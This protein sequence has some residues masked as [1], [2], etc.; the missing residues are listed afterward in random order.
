MKKLAVMLSMDN[1]SL[2]IVS[3]LPE[4]L[5]D[6]RMALAVPTIFLVSALDEASGLLGSG[7]YL[8]V[9][10]FL[11]GAGV[12]TGVG[13]SH[14]A[15][16]SSLLGRLALSLWCR[17][18]QDAGLP[19][20][21]FE[22]AQMLTPPILIGLSAGLHALAL[23]PS[24]TVLATLAAMLTWTCCA[25]LLQSCG[26]PAA[27]VKHSETA[28]GPSKL[29]DAH[30]KPLPA[31]TAG[32]ESWSG[33]WS[34]RP[35]SSNVCGNSGD[36]KDG[37]SGH[38]AKFASALR[39]CTPCAESSAGP[40]LSSPEALQVEPAPLPPAWQEPRRFRFPVIKLMLIATL[41]LADGGI[42]VWQALAPRCS[43]QAVTLA[44]AAPLFCALAALLLHV[45]AALAR[46]RTGRAHRPDA[47]S[48]L[49]Q[50][51][52]DA[53]ICDGE[54]ASSPASAAC[55]PRRSMSDW[56]QVA[57]EAP[58][59]SAVSSA[60]ALRLV[61]LWA[62][63]LAGGVAGGALGQGAAASLLLPVLLGFTGMPKVAASATVQL[64][65][66]GASAVAAT[67]L[68]VMERDGPALLTILLYQGGSFAGGLTGLLLK[69]V[70]ARGGGGGHARAPQAHAAV[71]RA[72]ALALAAI[73]V[74]TA[75][76]A[77]YTAVQDASS[78][79]AGFQDPCA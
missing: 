75:G 57:D 74:C 24:W 49:A 35:G 18:P 4:Y 66:F 13:L 20:I 60:S 77:A 28:L 63:A 61:G 3:A 1:N 70:R 51:L 31:A 11:L 78:S 19:L 44:L 34:S 9:F 64:V 23:L 53:D 43:A 22:V 67:A 15:V 72:S 8:P 14:A 79:S 68:L 36:D 62:A 33:V 12:K 29:V 25:A 47:E 45:R 2:G 58:M 50:P 76:V 73:A 59:P 10:L 46:L 71:Q 7:F 65:S 41:W 30:G 54:E 38:V 5:L 32:R 48:A 37:V 55:R 69:L 21:D 39:V 16:A 17:H 6:W 27:A 56:Q 40:V 52:L 26:R 42:Q